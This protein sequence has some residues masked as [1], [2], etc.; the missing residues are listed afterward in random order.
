MTNNDNNN[1]EK[2]YLIFLL[3]QNLYGLSIDNVS[4]IMEYQSP[5]KIPNLPPYVHGLFNLRGKVLPI[6]D[7][8][9][10][11]GQSN[12][13][14][15]KKTCIVVINYQYNNQLIYLS[16]LVDDV[17]DVIEIFASSLEKVPDINMKIN[18]EF[19]KNMFILNNQIVM[20]LDINQVFS[21][22]A[23]N[24]IAGIPND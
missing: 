9:V 5:T 20:L 2:K 7:L 10:Y 3:E 23:L 21:E 17:V 18:S 19:I 4:E 14:I 16:I 13:R 24:I 8:S 1:Q 15:L 12:T 11:L 6:I 22:K